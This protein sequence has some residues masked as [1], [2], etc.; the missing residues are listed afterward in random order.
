MS[1]WKQDITKKGLV[2]E[3][4]SQLQFYDGGEDES[5]KYKV[6]EIR[7]SAVYTRETKSYLSGLY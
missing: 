6:E 2:D 7:D 1:L 3:T 4:I 5:G